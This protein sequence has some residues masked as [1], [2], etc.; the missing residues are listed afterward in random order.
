LCGITG[1]WFRSNGANIADIIHA[2]NSVL[3]HRGPDS[4]DVWFDKHAGLALGHRRL[5]ILDL[6][7]EAAQP[8]TSVNGRFVITF[9]GEIY[10]FLELRSRLE[11]LGASFRGRSDTEVLL[12]GFEAWGIKQ[13]L[14]QAIGMFAMAVWD[15]DFGVLTLARDRIGEKPLYYGKSSECFVFGSELRALKKCPEFKYSVSQESIAY[16]FRYGYVPAPL[17]IYDQAKK[18][19][20]GCYLEVRDGGQTISDPIQYWSPFDNHI[21]GPEKAFSGGLH[22]SIEQLDE[23][24]GNVVKNQMLSDVPLGAFLSGGI[25]S[26]IVVAMMQKNSSRK[27]KTFSIGFHDKTYDEAPYAAQ[28]AKH[29]GTDHTELYVTAHDALSIVPMLAKMFDEPFSDSS[30]IPTYL[31]SKLARSHVTVALSGDGGDESFA[32]YPRYIAASKLT[33]IGRRFP[34]GLLPAIGRLTTANANI[35]SRFTSQRASKIAK[36]GMAIRQTGWRQIYDESVAVGPKEGVVGSSVVE[37]LIALRKLEP[38]VLKIAQK[39]PVAAGQ[40]LDL[41]TY[42]PDDIMVKVDR[43]TMHVSLESRAPF[44]DH[45]VVEF[46]AALPTTFKVQG[47]SSKVILKLLLERYLPRHLFERPKMGFSIPV[48][49]WLR[50]PLRDWA[51]DTLYGALKSSDFGINWQ[52]ILAKWKEHEIGKRN[53]ETLLWN[54]LVIADWIDHN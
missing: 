8:K 48:G 13:T 33:K 11:S 10:N 9:N 28:V 5:S 49:G 35:M 2:M 29:L 30:Q 23:L 42:L 32:G 50:G 53:H 52:V 15:K 6:S 25:D 19:L 41:L 45:R 54:A 38:K 51:Q 34:P 37:D 46:A 27:I 39:D 14:T 21:A 36:L 20:P 24:L 43:A 16:Y 44:L 31:V 3:E 26:S 22:E 18:L 17:S 7:Q 4:G 47:N 1:V 12:A 40:I